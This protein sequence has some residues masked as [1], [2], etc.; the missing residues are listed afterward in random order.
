MS[1]TYP[2][3]KWIAPYA[4]S[5]HLPSTMPALK[6]SQVPITCNP[7]Q[8]IRF[9]AFEPE[10]LMRNDPKGRQQL[11]NSAFQFVKD[12]GL[13]AQK[14]TKAVIMYVTRVR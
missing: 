9:F 4:K 3:E 5:T 8:N 1:D 13:D 6:K 2:Q 7:G 10:T 11:V 12:T 14:A